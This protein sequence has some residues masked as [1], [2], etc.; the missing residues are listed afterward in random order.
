MGRTGAT[1]ELSIQASSA[2]L[3]KRSIGLGRT[4]SI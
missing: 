2:L 1:R 3:R 4:L